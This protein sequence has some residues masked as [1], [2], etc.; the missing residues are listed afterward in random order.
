MS[1]ND[2][3]IIEQKKNENDGTNT[4]QI[5]IG[6]KIKNFIISVISIIIIVVIYLFIG[7]FTLYGCKI[8]QSNILPTD[9]NCMP[10][11]GTEPNIQQIQTNIFVTNTDPPLS[12]KLSFPYNKY[13]SKNSIIDILRKYKES[14]SVTSIS[15]Y[16]ISI[17]ESLISFNYSSMNIFYNLLNNLP[18]MLILLV[19]P[20]VTIFYVA[21]IFIID[22]IYLIYLWFYNMY[23][24]F[25]QNINKDNNNS[26]VWEDI[27][28][29][30]PFEFGISIIYVI[31]FLC[32][33]WFFL[34]G[35]PFIALIILLWCIFSIISYKGV[36]NIQ[37]TNVISII[38]DV[39]KYNKVTITTIISI[40]VIISAFS[41]LGTISGVFCI[42]T[43]I[44]IYY[45]FLSIDLFKSV[46]ENKLSKL[47]SYDQAKKTCN[48]MK[49][50][51]YKNLLNKLPFFSGGGNLLVNEIKKISNSIKNLKK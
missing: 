4:S 9:L 45:G 42:L 2:A 51:T 48:K 47:V 12:Q 38:I 16:L 37:E 49:T 3:T 21:F 39:F 40:F 20:I 29:N 28:F 33:F 19:G 27:S 32:L 43:I 50:D 46:D 35:I 6:N 30:K 22:H 23:W 41:N 26:P 14:P 24:L 17:L 13:N 1:S 15:N 7:G 8:G 34:M 18:E 11:G 10:Y 5:N 36:L 31:I 44:L 25:K